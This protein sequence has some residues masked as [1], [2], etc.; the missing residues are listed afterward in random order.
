MMSDNWIFERSSG[1]AGWR[2]KVCAEWIYD[3][4][5]E[6]CTCNKNDMIIK[7]SN[8]LPIINSWIAKEKI[9]KFSQLANGV[10]VVFI[11]QDEQQYK[12]ILEP[13][14]KKENE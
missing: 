13:Y 4:A 3:E 14:Q 12:L 2:C 11:W 10:E 7:A 1:Y 8:C 6:I 5:P 9:K